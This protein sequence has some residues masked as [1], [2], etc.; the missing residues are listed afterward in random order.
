M[1]HGHRMT[2]KMKFTLRGFSW[3]TDGSFCIYYLASTALHIQLGCLGVIVDELLSG[4][5]I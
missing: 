2:L 1:V 3:I 4:R 5:D